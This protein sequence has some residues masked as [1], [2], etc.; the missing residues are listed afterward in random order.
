[1]LLRGSQDL[2]FDRSDDHL[3]DMTLSFA[4]SCPSSSSSSERKFTGTGIDFS[5]FSVKSGKI[6]PL[7]SPPGVS[8]ITGWKKV[9]FVKNYR[10][11]TWVYEGVMLPGN[12]MILG[13]WRH[14]LDE[15]FIPGQ[16][17]P[18]VFWA[19]PEGHSLESRDNRLSLNRVH[20]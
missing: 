8:A 15:V 12:N 19:A 1:M 2:I 4:A 16:S 18:F 11:H 13:H 6:N 5:A 7:P 10:S 9:Q 14:S 3:V 17:G 20:G